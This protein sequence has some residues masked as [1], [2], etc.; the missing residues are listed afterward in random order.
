MGPF[1]SFFNQQTLEHSLYRWYEKDKLVLWNNFYGNFIG[2][3]KKKK[4]KKFQ[5]AHKI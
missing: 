1:F 4:K 3:T 2:T 5:V